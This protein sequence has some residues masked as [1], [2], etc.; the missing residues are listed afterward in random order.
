VNFSYNWLS[1]LVGGLDVPPGE[2]MQHITL[3]TAECEGVH[4]W[5]SHL[6]RVCAARV[7]SVEAIEGNKNVKAVVDTGRYGTKQVVCGAPNCRPGV[8]TAYVPSGSVLAGKEIRRAVI[9]GVE[10]DGMLASGA[11]LGLNRDA[12]GILELALESGAGLGAPDFIIEVDNK[13][14][15]HRPDLWGHHGMA[16]EVA[17]ILRKPL[18]DPV[19]LR[20]LPTG[21]ASIGVRIEVFELCP[22]YSALV[23]EN[24]TV[25]P[26]PLWLQARL[27]SVGLNP[28]NNIVDVTNYVMAELAQPMHAFD[29]DK[30]RGGIVVRTAKPGERIAALNGETYELTPS[31]LVIGDEREAVAIA[32]VIGGNESAIGPSTTRIVLESANFHAASVRKTAASLKLRTDASMR[33]EKSQDPANTL[34]GLARAVALLGEVSPGIRLA[35]GVADAAAPMRTPEP[36]ELPLAWLD[37]KLG[38]QVEPAEVRGILEALQFR[39]EEREAAVFSVRVPSWRATKDISIKDDLVEEVGRMIGYASIPPVAPL[40]PAVVPPRNELREYLYELRHTV[41]AQGFH[42]VYNYSFLSEETAAIFGAEHIRVTNPIAADQSLLRT[43]LLPGVW[44]NITENSKYFDEF[45]FFEIGVEIH[46]RAGGELPEEVH[47]LMAAVFRKEADAEGLFELKRLAECIAAEVQPRPVEARTWEH[48]ARTAEL[49]LS[50]ESVGRL[51]ELH[52]NMVERGRADVL[53]LDIDALMRLSKPERRYKPIRRYPSSAF[54]LSVIAP[55]RALVGSIERELSSFAGEG[56]ERIE[57]VRQYSGPPLPEGAKSV[58][59]RL[60]VA[61]PDRTLGADE[62]GAIRSRIID[63]MRSR[64]Y[65]LRV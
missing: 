51:F 56:L 9:G 29:A 42:E 10:S 4:E 59:Y 53:D 3:K 48:P 24:V 60:I 45:R 34:R 2:L 43:S 64:G 1:E 28:I 15:T 13:S 8:V 25:Q 11:E 65:D 26:S 7:L 38:R 16:R 57:Y 36:I 52:P 54:D 58:S 37:R 49:I 21:E 17:A 63:G 41:A 61:A 46:K 30:L 32:G 20:L 19:D 27:E 23:F 39:V 6:A 31:N 47:H 14:L 40:L 5:G 12:A 18:K 55:V 62:V 50:G 35:G 22:R 33:F 44:N